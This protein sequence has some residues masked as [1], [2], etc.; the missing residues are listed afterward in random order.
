MTITSIATTPNHPTLESVQQA[1]NHWR[2]NRGQ[3]KTIREYLWK[4]VSQI[5]PHYRQQRILSTLRLNHYQ[6]RKNLDSIP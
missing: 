1:F 4:Q 5:L 6:L 2:S 3:D